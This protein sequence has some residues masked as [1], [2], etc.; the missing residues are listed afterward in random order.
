SE[1]INL[2]KNVYNN[3]D[4]QIHL[5]DNVPK[6]PVKQINPLPTAVDKDSVKKSHIQ[7]S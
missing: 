3:K 5:S 2:N 7:K 1:R 6:L 4:R